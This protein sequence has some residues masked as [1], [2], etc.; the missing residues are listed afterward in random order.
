[1][2]LY[3]QP[4]DKKEKK[5]YTNNI[6]LYDV[7]GNTP[8]HLVAHF[9]YLN[10]GY[11]FTRSIK[12]NSVMLCN[13]LS[14]PISQVLNNEEKEIFKSLLQTLFLYHTKASAKILYNSIKERLDKVIDMKQ[15]L[16]TYYIY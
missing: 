14:P 10:E 5:Y 1:M 9:S 13:T 2:A 7:R 15:T 3:G 4:A 6:N 12:F 11:K 16:I 8:N